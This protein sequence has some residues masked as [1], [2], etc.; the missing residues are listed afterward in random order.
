[1]YS[2]SAAEY[3]HLPPFIA[4]VAVRR[5]CFGTSIP[6]AGLAM[7]AAHVADLRPRPPQ[8]LDMAFDIAAPEFG[9][10][11]ED[12]AFLQHQARARPKHLNLLQAGQGLVTFI[13]RLTEGPADLVAADL[14]RAAKTRRARPQARGFKD[15][16]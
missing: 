7:S 11:S 8:L 2:L 15:T 10:A 9:P 13:G 12:Q 3:R 6:H 1:L 14:N 4:G 5:G 16:H